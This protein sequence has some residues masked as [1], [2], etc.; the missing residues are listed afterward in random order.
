MG[1]LRRLK[2]SLKVKGVSP[3]AAVRAC[4]TL[5]GYLLPMYRLAQADGDLAAVGFFGSF[6]EELGAMRETIIEC[7]GIASDNVYLPEDSPE[8]SQLENL[9][10]GIFKNM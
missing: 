6:L 7:E 2:R 8:D 1:Q 3:V 4:E 9:F 10:A 5:S